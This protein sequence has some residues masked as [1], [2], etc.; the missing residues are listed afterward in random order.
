M[1][2]EGL[3]LNGINQLLACAADVNMCGGN[4][5]KTRKFLGVSMEVGI[6]VNAE[7]PKFKL[8]L[9]E[10]G[11]VEVWRTEVF[12]VCDKRQA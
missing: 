8:D 6:E 12:Q 7:T 5:N 3:R 10:L 2:Q 11:C 9:N 1:H 4:K